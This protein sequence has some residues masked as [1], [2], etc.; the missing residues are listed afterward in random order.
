MRLLTLFAS[1]CTV[2]QGFVRCMRTLNVPKMNK[3]T[4][5]LPASAHVVKPSSSKPFER[6]G[7]WH[8][9]KCGTLVFASKSKCFKCGASRHG[10]G[11]KAEK[12]ST[13]IN[14]PDMLE[15]AKTS[16]NFES[17]ESAVDL[18]LQSPKEIRSST[19]T[20]MLKI[21][22]RAGKPEKALALFNRIGKESNMK[23][24]PDAIL[25]AALFSSAAT[26]LAPEVIRDLFERM[27][28]TKTR[29]NKH[30]YCAAMTACCKNKDYSLALELFEELQ[31]S[32]IDMD[33]VCYNIGIQIHSHLKHYSQAFELYNDM[34]TDGIKRDDVTYAAI[35]SSCQRSGDWP[36]ALHIMKQVKKSKFKGANLQIYTAAMSAFA[37]G[38]ECSRAM[39]LYKELKEEGVRM[40]AP[41]YAAVLQALGAAE[42][43]RDGDVTDQLLQILSEMK[44]HGIKHTEFTLS[45]A[46]R[47]FES[48]K[49]YSYMVQVL[50]F[51]IAANILR[52][53]LGAPRIDLRK[54]NPSIIKATMLSVMYRIAV[55]KLPA[56]RDYI[57][58]IG[59][60]QPLL[61]SLTTFMKTEIAPADIL[62]TLIL[63][64]S[65]VR[66]LEYSIVKWK[67]TLSAT[68]ATTEKE[69]QI[70]I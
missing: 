16:G 36:S 5:K 31:A 56:R 57:F 18:L 37:K 21:Y 65:I 29:P 58:V 24:R 48:S 43:E 28:S 4:K 8:C 19:L 39:E 20:A 64:D 61:E 44:E 47:G 66:L 60:N 49:K 2:S 68:E 69:P 52:I 25:F 12:Q 45:Q 46:I 27:R 3:K 67:K 32:N 1:R 23:Q 30:I 35:L 38:G 13:R 26:A 41:L 10:K 33:T 55:D 62:H 17:V 50:E 22:G 14:L 9:T 11:K 51:G 42:V 70:V 63:N 34:I 40:D 54:V 59:R 6:A 15:E 53:D 7:D